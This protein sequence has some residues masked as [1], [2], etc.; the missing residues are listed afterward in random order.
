MEIPQNF[1]TDPESNGDDDISIHSGTEECHGSCRPKGPCRDIFIREAQMDARE[2]FDRGLEVGRDHSGDHVR[3]TSPR[4]LK[5][6]ERGAH[7]G[8]M[9]L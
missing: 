9:L 1:F 8:T 6:D 2:D 3:P 4:R 7:G 5:T